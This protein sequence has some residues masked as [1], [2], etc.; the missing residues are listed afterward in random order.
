MDPLSWMDS[1]L[2][3]SVVTQKSRV[4]IFAWS[5]SVFHNE[6]K[7]SLFFKTKQNIVQHLTPH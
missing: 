6:S 1:W 3:L 7:H 4:L 2:W 5:I